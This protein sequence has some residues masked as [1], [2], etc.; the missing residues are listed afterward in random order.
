MVAGGDAAFNPET[1]AD[2]VDVA[3][4][5]DGEEAVLAITDTVGAGA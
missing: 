3:V 4:V 5:G 1:I 2:F